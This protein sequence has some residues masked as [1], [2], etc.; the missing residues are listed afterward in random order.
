MGKVKLSVDEV[1]N[2]GNLGITRDINKIVCNA[3]I[4]CRLRELDFEQEL[5]RK[6]AGL[7]TFFPAGKFICYLNI[8]KD[9]SKGEMLFVNTN[10][11]IDRALDIV[12]ILFKGTP[13]LIN[14]FMKV[15]E[16]WALEYTEEL[17]LIEIVQL[18]RI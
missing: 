6:E 11:E 8:K 1:S 4:L 15:H 2:N 16:A 7:A 12:N 3:N 14:D 17:D 13:H 10:K 5:D 18:E 9:K